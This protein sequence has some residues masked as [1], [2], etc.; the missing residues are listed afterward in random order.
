M[1]LFLSEQ[2]EGRVRALLS[3][4]AVELPVLSESHVAGYLRDLA[5]TRSS[6]VALNHGRTSVDEVGVC[7]GIRDHRGDLVAGLMVAAPR[8]RM[9]EEQAYHTC[10][11]AR[12][13]A[14]EISRRMGHPGT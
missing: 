8:F 13:A 1:Q 2:P 10:H 6:G 14:E 9:G 12:L 11:A 3:S 4:G 5:E 7:A